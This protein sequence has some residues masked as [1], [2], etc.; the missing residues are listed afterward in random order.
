LE[1]AISTP[2]ARYED[3]VADPGIKDRKVVPT[4]PLV[5]RV[6]AGT[7][8]VVADHPWLQGEPLARAV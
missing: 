2:P 4:P 8:A 7:L 6:A 5:K 1:L 3:I